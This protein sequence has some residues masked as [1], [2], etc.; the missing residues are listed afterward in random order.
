MNV[1]LCP[2]CFTLALVKQEDDRLVV[3]PCKCSVESDNSNK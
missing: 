3:E 2:E 1:Y